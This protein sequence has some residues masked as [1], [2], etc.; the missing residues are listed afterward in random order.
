MGTSE[1]IDWCPAPL[2]VHSTVILT[3]EGHIGWSRYPPRCMSLAYFSHVHPNNIHL[4]Q[5]V[6]DV[7]TSYDAIVDLLETIEYLINQLDIYTR[8]PLTGAVTEI[9]VK[10]MVELI[11]TLALVTKQI[12]QNRPSKFVLTGT[13][14]V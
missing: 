10:I 9:L 13:P 14:L 11:S 3:C 8:I 12:K 6:K 7:N 4:N 2:I 5:T 1:G